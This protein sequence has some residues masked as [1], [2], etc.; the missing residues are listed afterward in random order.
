MEM[1]VARI[2]GGFPW[3]L[4]G[5][6]Q[7]KM[8]ALIQIASLTGV[9]GVSF[10]VVWVSLA[11]LCSATMMLRKPS[12][13]GA[14]AAEIGLPLL[15]TALVFNYG[16]RRVGAGPEASDTVRVTLIQPS[17]PQT[18]IWSPGTEDQR[19]HALLDLSRQALTNDTDVL[20]WPEAAVPKLL[21]YDQ[22]T[23]E[24]VTGLAQQYRVWMVIGADDA[25]PV[26]GKAPVFYNSS[27]L[28]D[29]QGR[30]AANYRK[31]SLVMFG[32]YV[33][34]SRWVPFFKWFTPVEGGFA[35][36]DKPGTF[37][38]PNLDISVSIL[39]CFEDT[40]AHVGRS[41]VTSAT[42]F[43]VNITNDGWFGESAEQ[44]QHATTALFRT[45]ENGIPLV[46][47]TN[48]GLTCWIDKY[49]RIRGFLTDAKGSIHGAGVFTLLLPRR[50]AQDIA[51]FY[52]RHG[53]V[54]GWS[55]VGLSIAAALATRFRCRL[56]SVI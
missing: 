13:R 55:C 20:I 32:E 19:F 16:L 8:L 24:A 49:G 5:V 12:T 43:L 4:I 50:P 21:R 40:F 15:I 2:F 41:G 56:E 33:P 27:F 17:I 42:D 44:W 53:D 45:V 35:A 46:R 3:N 37:T 1:I 39:I 26:A 36:G 7:Y 14:L 6:S 47:C 38:M 30:L 29:P 34:L 52:S 28:I 31:R 25:E 51:T 23:F 48:N 18:L 10:I 11:L 9:Y 22:E 54:F